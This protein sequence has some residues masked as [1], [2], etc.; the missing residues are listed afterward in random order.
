[1]IK[2]LRYSEWRLP[3]SPKYNPKTFSVFLKNFIF[4]IGDDRNLLLRFNRQRCATSRFECF[5]LHLKIRFGTDYHSK[6]KKH[7]QFR[8]DKILQ[9]L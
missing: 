1:V 4:N 7:L 2:N 8:H 6:T 5:L 3:F 9:V